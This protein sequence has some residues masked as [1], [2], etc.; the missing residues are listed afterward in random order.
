MWDTYKDFEAAGIAPR[1]LTKLMKA[2]RASASS[3]LNGRRHPSKDAEERLIAI[4]GAA[5]MALR[6]GY[7][8]IP[9]SVKPRQ[10]DKLLVE[11]LQRYLPKVR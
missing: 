6:H 10:R 5:E 1:H 7:L 2:T 4:A 11:A 8:P 9:D 3:W